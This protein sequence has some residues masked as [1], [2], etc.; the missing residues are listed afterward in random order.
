[1]QI[2]YLKG[3]LWLLP[4]NQRVRNDIFGCRQYSTLPKHLKIK[5][6]NIKVKGRQ[7][8]DYENLLKISKNFKN[9]D[10]K[11]RFILAGLRPTKSS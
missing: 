7:C 6:I 2:L 1:M 9:T 4:Q 11:E 8:P 10:S 3:Y 5:K